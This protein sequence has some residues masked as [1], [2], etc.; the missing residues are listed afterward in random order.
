MGGLGAVAGAM[1]GEKKKINVIN[2]LYISIY[3]TVPTK[4]LINITIVKGSV[5]KNTELYTKIDKFI[6]EYKAMFNYILQSN[7]QKS[8]SK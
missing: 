4:L 3:T 6:S 5:R 8:S 2:G 1:A 7:T